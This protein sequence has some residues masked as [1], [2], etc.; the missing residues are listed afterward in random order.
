MFAGEG[1]AVAYHQIRRVVHEGAEFLDPIASEQVEVDAGVDAALAEV[2]VEGG[3]IAVFIEQ[4]VEV[5]QVAAELFW[6][7]AGILPALPGVWL[8]GDEDGGTQCGF[9]DGPEL[10]R[11]PWIIAELHG[12]VV[13]GLLEIHHQGAGAVVGLALAF[14]AEL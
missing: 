10:A 1:A 13:S 7:H 6:G 12:D 9:A 14:A 3:E 8:A 5:A 11:F 4:L 2:A